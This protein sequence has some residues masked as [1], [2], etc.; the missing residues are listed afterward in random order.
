MPETF[1]CHVISTFRAYSAALALSENRRASLACQ[2]TKARDHARR[3][4]AG[5]S[6]T[7]GAPVDPNHRDELCR[8]ASEETFV[9]DI[10]V[11]ARDFLLDNF[12]PEFDRDIEHN[13]TC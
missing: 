8:G 6:I 1:T 5:L 13:R 10:N 7:D 3:Y 2:L 11:V 12:H 4:G 9:C